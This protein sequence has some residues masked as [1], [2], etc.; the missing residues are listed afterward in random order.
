MSS[1]IDE[2]VLVFKL[3]PHHR[4][5]AVFYFV[6]CHFGVLVLLFNYALKVFA[7]LLWLQLIFFFENVFKNLC[8]SVGVAES[9]AHAVIVVLKL[10]LE[11]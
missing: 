7:P 10:N 2:L 5:G 3:K 1:V 6:M 11:N 9:E 8:V 4:L